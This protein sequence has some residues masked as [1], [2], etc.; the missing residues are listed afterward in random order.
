MTPVIDRYGK[1]PNRRSYSFLLFYDLIDSTAARAG[2]DGADVEDYRTAVEGC[3]QFINRQFRALIAQAS[4]ADTEIFLWNGTGSSTNDCKHI[5]IGGSTAVKYLDESL[6]SLLNALEAYPMCRLR[7]YMVPCTF[8]NTTVSRQEFST[9]AEGKRFWEHWS[10]V[11]KKLSSFES[12]LAAGES[13]LA[14]VSERLIRD[15][16]VPDGI[17]WSSAR[18]AEVTSEIEMLSRTVRAKYGAFTV[19]RAVYGRT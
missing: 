5:L 17:S 3:K 13:F 16:T 6:R 8:A 4:R 1:L 14:I 11:A 12:G 15:F 19:D 2:Q 7:I 9:E 10:R 18:E